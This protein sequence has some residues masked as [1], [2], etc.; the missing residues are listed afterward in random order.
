[1]YN[2]AWVQFPK[3]VHSFHKHPGLLSVRS[4]SSHMQ[5]RT[6]A[7][8]IACMDLLLVWWQQQQSIT[9]GTRTEGRIN[10]HKKDLSI[11]LSLSRTPSSAGGTQS[12]EFVTLANTQ[13]QQPASR[14]PLR[15][16]ESD[17]TGFTSRSQVNN[18]LHTNTQT[19]STVK[20]KAHTRVCLVN[21][22]LCENPSSTSASAS[23]QQD[24]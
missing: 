5:T 2:A 17:T 16:K 9:E 21:I 23:S 11:C 24:L 8:A 10:Q 14:L 20:S 22:R 12:S 3:S 19:K 15:W 4:A 13:A 6:R 1:M 18:K 7:H